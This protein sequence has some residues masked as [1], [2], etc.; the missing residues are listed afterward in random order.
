MPAAWMIEKRR[1]VARD[2]RTPTVTRPDLSD[3][4]GEWVHALPWD[5]W[6]TFTFAV[7]IHPDQAGQRYQE[8]ARQLQGETGTTM[9]HARAL[10]YQK[11]GVV[12]FHALIW[13]VNRGTHRKTWERKWEEIGGGWCAIYPYDRMRAAS[14]YLG[15]Y[16]VKGGEIDHLT[17][18]ESRW[19]PDDVRIR[20]RGAE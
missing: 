3:P 5:W 14:F 6:A 2:A 8:W 13:G 1:W 20:H 10:E 19:C 9:Q 4:Y 12:H 17:F 16:A 11:R 18:G 7:W 15:K